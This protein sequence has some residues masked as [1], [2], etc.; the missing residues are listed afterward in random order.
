MNLLNLHFNAMANGFVNRISYILFHIFLSL[1][2]EGLR[3]FNEED[4]LKFLVLLVELSHT[5]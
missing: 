4:F 2:E 1:N 5:S 3:R